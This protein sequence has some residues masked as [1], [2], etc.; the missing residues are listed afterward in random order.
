MPETPE[1]AQ[2]LFEIKGVLTKFMRMLFPVEQ[3]AGIF[4]LRCR[5]SE[6]PNTS[7]GRQF[8]ARGLRSHR[9]AWRLQRAFRADNA[10][11]AGHKNVDRTPRYLEGPTVVRVGRHRQHPS[12]RTVSPEARDLFHRF[13]PKFFGPSFGYTNTDESEKGR[14][15]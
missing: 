3:R 7:R 15:H 2:N 1:K 6:L 10:C 4:Q 5:S 11:A 13:R 12:E 9:S 8:L 14:H